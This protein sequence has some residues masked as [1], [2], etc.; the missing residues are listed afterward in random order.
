MQFSIDRDALL[1]RVR[2]VHAVLGTKETIPALSYLRFEADGQMLTIAGNDLAV[3]QEIIIPEFACEPFSVGIHGQKLLTSQDVLA[4]GQITITLEEGH[5]LLTQ[6]KKTKIKLP[7]LP[8]KDL[9]ARITLPDLATD[10]QAIQ[11]LHEG[12][13]GAVLA[14]L[15]RLV[16]P[17]MSDIEARDKIAAVLLQQKG[18]NLE[19]VAFDYASVNHATTP[20]ASLPEGH[21]FLPRE[22]VG[23]VCGVLGELE[24]VKVART[25]GKALFLFADGF[26]AIQ[27]KQQDLP[28][29][30]DAILRG[31]NHP[32]E[33]ATCRSA[34]LKPL[35]SAVKLCDN[36]S[37]GVSVKLTSDGDGEVS[38]VATGDG[39]SAQ[40]PLGPH[41]WQG[42]LPLPIL[43][44]LP[45]L[46]RCRSEEM[47]FSWDRKPLGLDEHGRQKFYGPIVVTSK[48][49]VGGTPI[50]FTN[51]NT[52]L[53]FSE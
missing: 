24:L 39:Q 8:E 12:I 25:Q 47:V 36:K 16:A 10:P 27:Q 41:S 17:A 29:G 15:V 14:E 3:Y 50:Y 13:S 32:N 51:R 45:S 26:I 33:I 34:F 6:G 4:K 7:T 20:S 37:S 1:S 53:N 5:A 42:S 9:T 22:I 11:L 23:K 48:E 44:L 21:C 49:V 2:R 19:A 30:L 35:E 40:F 52:G 18:E 31:G 38:L 28:G 43:T 46:Q